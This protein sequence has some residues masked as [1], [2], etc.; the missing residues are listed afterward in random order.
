MVSARPRLPRKSNSPSLRKTWGHSESVGA[1]VPVCVRHHSAHGRPA[2][3]DGGRDTLF[4]FLGALL[5]PWSW[6]KVVLIGLE[7][8]AVW[9]VAS[10]W[11][12]MITYPHAI[13]GQA[14]HL[15]VGLLGGMVIPIREIES[16]FPAHRQWPGFLGPLLQYA[17]AAFP[18]AGSTETVLH[19]SQPAVVWRVIGRD[20]PVT[21]VHVHADDSRRMLDMLSRAI[22]LAA[23]SS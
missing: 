22:S 8:Y 18:V 23:S 5:L 21:Q 11:A 6:L 15:R 19:L 7:L 9:F 10:T 14:L 12:A 4:A 3:L 20:V 13:R 17:T 2:W 1:G 16:A